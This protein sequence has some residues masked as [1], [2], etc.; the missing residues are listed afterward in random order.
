VNNH[1]F[2]GDQDT[3]VLAEGLTPYIGAGN[4]WFIGNTDTGI[5]AQGLTPYVGANGNWWVGETD[6]GIF[7]GGVK[8]EGTAEVGQ[9]I[10][11]KAVDE[12]GKPTEWV[13]ASKRTVHRGR[14]IKLWEHTFDEDVADTSEFDDGIADYVLGNNQVFTTDE[15]GNPL[16]IR[17]LWYDIYWGAGSKAAATKAP[18]VGLFA[19]N[20]EYKIRERF[21]TGVHSEYTLYADRGSKDNN[22][23]DEGY[24]WGFV[25]WEKILGEEY[26]NSNIN[27]RGTA[28]TYNCYPSVNQVRH[29]LNT[30]CALSAFVALPGVIKAGTT[31]KVWVEVAE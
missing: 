8:I 18:S 26:S 1:W 11:V 3:G 21:L 31:Y 10:V 27:W 7:A 30:D 5:T 23:G 29:I 28:S 4:H 2:I 6:S 15:N 14:I 19:F 24:R 20:T 12:N 22:I 13:P 9:T 16:K 25:D 17:R